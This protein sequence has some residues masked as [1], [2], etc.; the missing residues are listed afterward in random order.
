MNAFVFPGQGSQAVGMGKSLY[1]TYPTAK[2]ILDKANEVLG[3]SLTELCFN[4]PEETL[5]QTQHAQ[6]ALF[7]VSIATYRILKEKGLEPKF[8]AG[9]SLGEYS[10]LVAAGG[11]DFE[12]GLKLVAERGRLMAEAGKSEPGTMAAVLGMSDDEIRAV[13]EEISKTVGVVVVANYNCP[14]QV[15]VSGSVV[16]V[17]EAIK[18]LKE[19]KKKA[20]PLPVSGAFHS[21]LLK[22]AGEQFS[23]VLDGVEFHPASLPVVSNATAEASID[24]VVL[25]SALARQMTSSVLWESSVKKM[26][27][28]GAKTFV[29]VGTGSVLSGLIKK[30]N[31]E[32]VTYQTSDATALE[33]TVSALK[34]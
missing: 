4:G 10:A 14:G 13:C 30:I 15:V 8:V 24:A 19:M 34:S 9:H 32:V 16:G 3:Y 12:A 20:I 22:D 31:K 25:K 18:K 17:Q 7:S 21:P 23:K 2:N 26:V 6:P 11:L 5:K 27:E 1:D 28:Q 29:E 33:S